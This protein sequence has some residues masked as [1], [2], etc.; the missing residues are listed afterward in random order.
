M[1]R[2]SGGLPL[3]LG[4]LLGMPACAGP[5]A[6]APR[7]PAVIVGFGEAIDPAAP[8]T[9]TLLAQ[10]SGAGVRLVATIAPHSAAYQLDCP[11]ADPDCSRALVALRAH[12]AV[13]T[14]DLDQK[15]GFR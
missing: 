2:R 7:G 5:T 3:V 11:P 4:A 1:M 9:L 14:V 10:A 8:A 13:R 12:P 15:K 6:A